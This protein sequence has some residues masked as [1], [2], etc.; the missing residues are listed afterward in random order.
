MS[1]RCVNAIAA[2][3][4]RAGGRAARLF[5]E[6]IDWLEVERLPGELLSSP[7]C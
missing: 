3:Q 7:P 2:E 6:P 5:M 4:I 1:R